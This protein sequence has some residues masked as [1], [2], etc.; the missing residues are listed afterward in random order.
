[1]NTSLEASTVL[2]RAVAAQSLHGLALVQSVV[3]GKPAGPTCFATDSSP[4]TRFDFIFANSV[5]I[6]AFQQFTIRED[7]SV[8]VHRA[9]E[10]TLC[11]KQC[12]QSGVRYRK[13]TSLPGWQPLKREEEEDALAWQHAQPLLAHISEQWHTCMQGNNVDWG[14][15]MAS[16][17][18]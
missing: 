1:M 6:S 4:S 12:T 5:A 17:V 15:E 11:F 3:D 9:L 7:V 18:A 13:P 16:E 2:S 8:P 10:T 14:L